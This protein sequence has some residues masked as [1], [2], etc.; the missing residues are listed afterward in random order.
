MQKYSYAYKDKNRVCLI[1]LENKRTQVYI[2]KVYNKTPTP[3]FNLSMKL[4]L[5]SLKWTFS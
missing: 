5:F 4:A 1:V 2:N 3:K